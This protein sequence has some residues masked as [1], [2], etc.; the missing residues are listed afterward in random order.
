M[1]MLYELYQKLLDENREL[2]AKL[3]RYESMEEN[4][5]KVNENSIDEALRRV[6]EAASKIK[7]TVPK[8]EIRGRTND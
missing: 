4:H 5:P 3:A 7:F 6:G 1:G 8:L 2:K